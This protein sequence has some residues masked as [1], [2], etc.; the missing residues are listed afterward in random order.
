MINY[1]VQRRFEMKNPELKIPEGV[2][3]ELVEKLEKFQDQILTL[4]RN[5]KVGTILL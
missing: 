1:Q 2:S 5:Y 4:V 3:A